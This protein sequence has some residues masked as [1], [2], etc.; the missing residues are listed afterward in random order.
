MSPRSSPRRCNC[1]SPAN[2]A[3]R[4][5]DTTGYWERSR[6][7]ADA[8]HLLGLVRA[9]AGDHADAAA[10]IARAAQLHPEVPAFHYN[11]GTVQE[12]AGDYNAAETAY[13]RAIVIAPD[14]MQAHFNLGTILR[15]HGRHPEA[16][17]CLRRAIEIDSGHVQP[18]LILANCLA[19]YGATDEAAEGFLGG[20]GT[21]AGRTPTPTTGWQASQE[22]PAIWSRRL[23]ICGAASPPK[24]LM[25][26]CCGLANWATSSCAS[27]RCTRR[28]AC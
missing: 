1:I 5:T 2:C 6:D 11:L 27:A 8:L 15:R 17:A 21:G 7:N 25:P 22:R 23:T 13:R 14:H 4:R 26:R 18:H 24:G 3:T 10:R 12:A 9:A 16:I 19:E 20:A 28:P